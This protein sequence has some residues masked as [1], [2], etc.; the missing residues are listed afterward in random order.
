MHLLTGEYSIHISYLGPPTSISVPKPMQSLV[1]QSQHFS[2]QHLTSQCIIIGHG[3][4]IFA[5]FNCDL[6]LIHGKFPSTAIKS[7]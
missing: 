7:F 2:S 4:L 5:T 3:P 1:I 6:Y